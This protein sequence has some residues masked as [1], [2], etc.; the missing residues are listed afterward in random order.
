MAVRFLERKGYKILETN[1]RHSR[2]EVD[3]IAQKEGH[4]IVFAEVKT[5]STA[6]FGTPE[7]SVTP[8]KKEKLYE[9]AEAFLEQ[10][11][12]ETEIRFDIISIVKDG[13]KEEIYHIE[14][15]FF[16]VE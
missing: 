7:E 13:G 9:A 11:D 12:L 2:A 3:V 5:R 10:R 6:Y 14:D 16:G 8:L 15:A 4:I 1:W